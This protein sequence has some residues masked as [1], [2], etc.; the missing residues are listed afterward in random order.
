MGRLQ[1][2]AEAVMEILKDVSR[3]KCQLTPAL[4]E[5]AFSTNEQL[6]RLIDSVPAAHPGHELTPVFQEA[7]LNILDNLA[8][9]IKGDYEKRFADLQSRIDKC[10]SFQCLIK[11]VNE[12]SEMVGELINLSIERSDYSNDF[13]FELSKDLYD[14]EGK[15][16]SYQEFN[17]D[18]HNMSTH[19][20]DN[21]LEHTKDINH[22]VDSCS[23]P[24]DIRNV[25][26]TKLNTISNAI[27]SKR[28]MDDIKLRQ[29]DDKISELQINLSTYEK[30]I[31]QVRQR[32]ETLEKEVMLDELTGINNR[33]SYDLHIMECVRRY[34]S[35]HDKFSLILVDIDHFKKINDT[36]GHKAGNKCLQ[37]VARLI[38]S[39]LRQS[40]FFARYGGEELIAVLHQC[41]AQNASKVA[42]KIRRRIENTRFCYRDDT[43]SITISLGVTEAIES[44]IETE[45]PFI[46]VDE[47]M[48][49]AKLNGRNRVCLSTDLQ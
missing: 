28:K 41:D 40:D 1:A 45:T 38:K 18:T 20:N 32:S 22:A 27:D 19:F 25:I 30:E 10:D 5:D 37:E 48:Y 12:V 7:L 11:M 43:I 42:E 46:R 35:S 23:N 3:R 13:L 16:S 2:M 17:R 36:Y 31:L 34:R 26:A 8:P 44:D 29:A 4:L 14:M 9:M 47:A 15:L 39:C 6:T 33:R 21:I 24:H 49:K